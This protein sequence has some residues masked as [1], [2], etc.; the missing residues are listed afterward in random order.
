[1]SQTAT[2][3]Q[4]IQKQAEEPEGKA[5]PLLAGLVRNPSFSMRD[6]AVAFYAVF[7]ARLNGKI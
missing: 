6:G 4:A 3:Y 7:L 5:M 2:V 1:M